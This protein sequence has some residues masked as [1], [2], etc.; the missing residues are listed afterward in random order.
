MKPHDKLTISV[1]PTLKYMK[2]Y[3]YRERNTQEINCN[4]VKMLHNHP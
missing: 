4:M 2:I 1:K 3:Q